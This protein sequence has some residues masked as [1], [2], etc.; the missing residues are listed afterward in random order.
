MTTR[1]RAMYDFSGEPNTSELSIV[2]DEILTLTRTD[3]G[4]GWWEGTNSRG[5]TG[6]FPEAY[7]QIHHQEPVKTAAVATPQVTAVQAVAAPAAAP[8]RYDQSA[9]DWSEQQDDWEDDWDEDNETY[10]EIGPGNQARSQPV[11]M[12]QQQH[13]QQQSHHNQLP[14]YQN[15]SSLP[16]TPSDDTIS[17]T[18]TSAPLKK[19]GIFAKSGD[20]YILGT[21]NVSVA[22]GE[23]VFINQIE[24]GSY[25]WKQVRDP[26]N[27]RVA[28]P[29]KETKFKG[30]KSFIAYQLTPSFN[31]IAVSRRYKHFDWLH[32]RLLEKFCL[33]PIPPL[34]DKQISGR[35]EDQF[36]EHRRV[37]LQE[38]VDWVCRHPVLSICEVWMHFLTCTDEKRWKTG[39]RTAEKDILV[40][41]TYCAAIFPP[42]KQ[43]L[44][45]QIDGQ[46]ENCSLFVHA[47]DGAVKS[48]F[49][50]SAEQVK[51]YQMQWKKDFQRVG[52][53]FSE[54]ARA[55]EVDERRAITNI[56]LS[57]SVGQA[58]GVFISIGQMFGEQPNI[59]WIPFCDRLHIY[60][61]VLTGF[62]DMLAVHRG[63][64]QKRKE[65]ERLTA[66]QKMGNAQLQE[67]GR[68]TDIMSYAVLA[69][70]NHFRQER[71]VHLKETMR[72]LIA[73]QIV[74]Y[75]DIIGKLQAAQR[76]FE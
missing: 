69:E 11:N 67:V 31:N 32:E 16:P 53:S 19:S 43:L 73:A 62:P 23:R 30:M 55:L 27:V 74:F 76:F 26:Y 54:L 33:I 57:N 70:M 36:V 12:Q 20:S 51:R 41:A 58:A 35:Y 42:E 21:T 17:M 34:P 50:I 49:A 61:G 29:K 6:L 18:S 59:D 3:V 24:N 37:Q 72:N 60:R 39:K 28:S 66:E 48:L 40:G 63:A 38:F 65:C 15:A 14:H 75:Q 64:M 1:V 7:V 10:S 8:P 52:E 9:D 47:M 5:Q 13:Q 46:T 44:Q 45:S 68:R 22:D 25:F 2:A 71:D 4:E 56:N